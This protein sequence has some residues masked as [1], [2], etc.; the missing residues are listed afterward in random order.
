MRGFL[1]ERLSAV[2][3][4]PLRGEADLVG[5]EIEIPVGLCCAGHPWSYTTNAL[6]SVP[7][8]DFVVVFGNMA[9]EEE[10]S[11]IPEFGYRG[12]CVCI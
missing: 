6:F 12:L 10:H 11:Y 2:M 7:L 8:V 3:L 4:K 9:G 1:E 5:I